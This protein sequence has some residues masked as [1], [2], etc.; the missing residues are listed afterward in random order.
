MK[1][2]HNKQGHGPLSQITNL[3]GKAAR[4]QVLKY[5]NRDNNKEVKGTENCDEE[6]TQQ[7][8]S[9]TALTRKGPSSPLFRRCLTKRF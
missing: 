5:Y 8:K 6:Q 1:S 7:K 9:R 3:R 2:K 4:V